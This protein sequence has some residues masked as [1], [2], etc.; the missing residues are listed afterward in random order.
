V[1][2]RCQDPAMT[3]APS[4]GSTSASEARSMHGRS[5][6]RA[7]Y[8]TT[9][10]GFVF[11]VLF[12]LAYWLGSAV[13]GP[14]ATDGEIRA[15]YANSGKRRLTLVA[16]YLMPFAGIAFLWFIVA[17]RMWISGS[18]RRENVLLSNI[19]L[20]SGILFIAMFFAAASAYAAV[21]ASVEF[22]GARVDPIVARQLPLYG[23]TLLFVFA[24]RMGAMFVF[25]TSSIGRSAGILPTWYTGAGY[26]VGLFLLLSASFSRGLV[27]VFPL[28]VVTLCFLL[29]V[30]ASRIPDD[31]DRPAPEAVVR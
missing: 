24:M 2:E 15:F 10:V 19:Q 22:A 16:L 14:D 31:F 3:Y 21:A 18:V 17:L 20:V 1:Q 28:W 6:R 12:I 7:A 4:G 23:S 29:L 8:L 9:A 5:L 26:A 11:A 13:P 30:R 27:L 25:T